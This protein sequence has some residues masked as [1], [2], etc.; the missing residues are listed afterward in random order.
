MGG[1]KARMGRRGTRHYRGQSKEEV[2]EEADMK[3]ALE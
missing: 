2:E 3:K 1:Q